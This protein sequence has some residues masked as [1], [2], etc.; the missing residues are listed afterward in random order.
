MNELC[1]R[2]RDA[3][4]FHCFLFRCGSAVTRMAA[5]AP[6]VTGS[7]RLTESLADRLSRS[8]NALWHTSM[9]NCSN[10]LPATCAVPL[11]SGAAVL[12]QL[13]CTVRA[14]QQPNAAREPRARVQSQIAAKAQQLSCGSQDAAGL[15]VAAQGPGWPQHA[16]L[17][18]TVQP[19]I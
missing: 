8:M 3:A 6:A 2:T 12:Q 15:A 14:N 1:L 10:G 16:M 19:H 9:L 7:W 11:G 5:A 17:S 13:S 4:L 18:A